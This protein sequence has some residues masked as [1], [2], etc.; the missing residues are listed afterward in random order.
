[1]KLKIGKKYK[2]GSGDKVEIIAKDEKKV[3]FFL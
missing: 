1:M 2:L 3:K